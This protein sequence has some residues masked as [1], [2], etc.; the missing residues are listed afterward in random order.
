MINAIFKLGY[1]ELLPEVIMSLNASFKKIF[2][3]YSKNPKKI[4]STIRN[5]KE[6]ILTILYKAYIEYS[7]DIKQDE[8]LIK[9][10][11]SILEIFVNQDYEE[12][13]VILDEFRTH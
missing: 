1:T 6:R 11:E 4:I 10:F 12:F 9:S 3:H 5:N 8:D 7:D 13:A 2:K